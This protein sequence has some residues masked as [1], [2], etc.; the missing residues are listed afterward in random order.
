M[1]IVDRRAGDHG[2]GLEGLDLRRELHGLVLQRR[3]LRL[4]LRVLVLEGVVVPVKYHLVLVRA[5]R[6][7]R[8]VDALDDDLREVGVV[9]V[10][11]LDLIA[12]LG[13]ELFAAEVDEVD[14]PVLARGGVE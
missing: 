5:E 4:E 1:H 14:R 2:Q 6:A 9:G 13:E 11:R 7:L 3:E 10:L 12:P 8:R